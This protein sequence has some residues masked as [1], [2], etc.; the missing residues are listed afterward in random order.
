MLDL[1]KILHLLGV[2]MVFLAFGG[3][4]LHAINGGEK[5]EN[6]FRRHVMLTHGIGL[7][8]LLISG[9]GMLARFGIH[10]PWPGWVVGKFIIWL[11]LGVLIAF[12]YKKAERGKTLWFAVLLLGVVSAYLALLKPF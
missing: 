4:I 11:L 1:Y 6:I 10:W 5:R 7:A 9:F 2:M 12:V 8:F 3:V